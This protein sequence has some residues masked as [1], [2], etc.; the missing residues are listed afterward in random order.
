MEINFVAVLLGAAAM[1]IVGFLMHGP[2]GGKLWMR[3][4]NITPTGNEKFSDMV[5]QMIMNY[6]VNVV[7]GVVMSMIYYFIFASG[8]S[9]T[10]TALR[11]AIWA[12]WLWLGFCVVSSSMNVIWMKHSKKL[13]L[14]DS[15]S[16]LLSMMAMGAVIAGSM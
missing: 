6:V 9:G 15:L 4:A 7:M 12:F 2:I 14:Y 3:L 16:F 10:A 11:G 13:F 8:L 1:F 5:P